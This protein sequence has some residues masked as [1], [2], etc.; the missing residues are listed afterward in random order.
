MTKCVKETPRE[1]HQCPARPTQTPRHGHSP[2]EPS[3]VSVESL[4][5]QLEGL[6]PAGI[7]TLGHTSQG[8]HWCHSCN[9]A[10]PTRPRAL[11]SSGVRPLLRVLRTA[12]APADH[13]GMRRQGGVNSQ[14]VV[15]HRPPPRPPRVVTGLTDAQPHPAP[16]ECL[17]IYLPG[18]DNSR[19]ARG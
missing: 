15:I 19:A 11:A 18:Q 12:A 2:S 7:C 13:V 4:H 16:D 5:P 3:D 9:S 1:P 14:H 8:S 6:C 17:A 10:V